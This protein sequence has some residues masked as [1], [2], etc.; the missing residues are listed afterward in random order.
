VGDG[1]LLYADASSV[2]ILYRD[3]PPPRT[4]AAGF[5][6]QIDAKAWRRT[7][8]A[9]QPDSTVS[10]WQGQDGSTLTLAVVSAS[11]MTVATVTRI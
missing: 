9:V 5:E 11:D 3:A 4:I 7:L 10:T 2:T 8:S 6:G 1:E